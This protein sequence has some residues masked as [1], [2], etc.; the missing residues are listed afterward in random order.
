M[1]PRLLSTPVELAVEPDLA[2]QEALFEKVAAEFAAPLL[3]LAPAKR[4][5]HRATEFRLP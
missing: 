4:V 3:R 1:P 5:S 2:A